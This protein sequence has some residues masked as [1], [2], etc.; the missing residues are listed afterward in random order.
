MY[1]TASVP[2]CTR[3]EYKFGFK[4]KKKSVPRPPSQNSTCSSEVSTSEFA[5]IENTLLDLL[6]DAEERRKDLAR[7]VDSE[8]AVVELQCLQRPSAKMILLSLPC[9]TK[10][11]GSELT[12]GRTV[13]LLR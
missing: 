12:L 6:S 9:A 2:S 1:V 4:K 3:A 8:A 11:L 7:T 13:G 5:V 10:L